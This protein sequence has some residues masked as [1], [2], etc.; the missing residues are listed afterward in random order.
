VRV[1]GDLD[2]GGVTAV[3]PAL[4][5]ALRPGELVV[6]LRDTGY[7]SSA[8]VAMLMELTAAARHRGTALAVQVA[9]GSP[10]ARVLELTG[11]GAVLPVVVP[12]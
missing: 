11:L 7:V 2:L 10:L 3:R 4:F 6:D 1:S 9:P 12:V 5:A 8:G